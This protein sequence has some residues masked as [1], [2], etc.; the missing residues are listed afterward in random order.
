MKREFLKTL[1]LSEEQIDSIMDEHGSTVNQVKGERDNLKTENGGLKDEIKN[2][3]G[4]I[5]VLSKTAGTSEELAKELERVK[6]ENASWQDKY[7]KS[8]LQANVKL[9]V[10][11]EA[12]DANDILFFVN[13]ESLKLNEDGSV[14]GLDEQLKTL[15][16]S[17]PYLFNTSSQQQTPPPGGQDD[18]LTPPPPP[19]G[20]TPGSQQRGNN[21][22]DPDPAA[23]ALADIERRH[24]KQK[25]E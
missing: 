24:G 18:D 12:N 3:D 11:K 19:S 13:T 16:E 7:S 22:K 20:F 5:E 4:Q 2:R 8:Q 9:A 17:K 21:P 14:E 1:G 25:E 10:A 6:V 15:K 23:L